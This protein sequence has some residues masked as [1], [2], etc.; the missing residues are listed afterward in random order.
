MV[1]L[2]DGLLSSQPHYEFGLRSIVSILRSAGE[3]KKEDQG[4]D[5]HYLISQVK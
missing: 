1:E 2:C 5:E 4:E 3:L